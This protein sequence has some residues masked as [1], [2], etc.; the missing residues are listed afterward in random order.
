M[1]GFHQLDVLPEMN[2]IDLCKFRTIDRVI[3]ES[4][5]SLDWL[6]RGKN[7]L[8]L[9][10]HGIGKTYISAAIC[11]QALRAAY[12]IRRT[13]HSTLQLTFSQYGARDPQLST[14]ATNL[15]I[16]DDLFPSGL[17]EPG[18]EQQLWKYL[19][20][21]SFHS[22]VMLITTLPP[23]SWHLPNDPAVLSYV[24]SVLQE[25]IVIE[26]NPVNCCRT[27]TKKKF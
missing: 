18:K 17:N 16:V 3:W 6:S 20:D 26:I 12:S 2:T 7:I 10:P 25:T 9:G 15:L 13:T 22:S 4:L 5:A 11:N 23:G 21:F 1:L 14:V 8:M 19:A 27:R 24:N